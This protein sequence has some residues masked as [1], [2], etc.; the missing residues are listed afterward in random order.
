MPITDGKMDGWRR[1][2]KQVR[3]SYSGG[4]VF[5]IDTITII[6]IHY[7]SFCSSTL[8]EEKTIFQKFWLEDKG[9]Q[10]LI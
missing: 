9:S 4:C 10:S 7:R 6:G 1:T 8:K 5:K 2:S 3:N